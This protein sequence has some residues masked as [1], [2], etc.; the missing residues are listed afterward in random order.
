MSEKKLITC[1]IQESLSHEII[2]Y[3]HEKKK[4]LTA[5][6]FS[7]RGMSFTNH[8]DVRQMDVLSVVVEESNAK[9]VF[10]YIFEKG[11]INRMHGGMIFQE[12]LGRSTLYE[13]PNL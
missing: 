7:A 9:E 6:K 11:K 8:L 5:N 13:L 4:I 12:K 3:L 2:E 1:I 10:E